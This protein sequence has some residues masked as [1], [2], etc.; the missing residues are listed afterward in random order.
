M[1]IYYMSNGNRVYKIS[2]KS[3]EKWLNGYQKTNFFFGPS[4]TVGQ[5]IYIVCPTVEDGPK[6]KLAFWYPVS[7]FSSDCHEILPGCTVGYDVSIKTSLYP[8]SD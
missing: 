6:W 5:T 8:P 7:Q 3:L 4:S 2:W 1:D